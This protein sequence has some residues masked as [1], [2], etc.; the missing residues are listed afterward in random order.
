MST[1]PSAAANISALLVDT[2]PLL[3]LVNRRD[4]HYEWVRTLLAGYTGRLFT[5]E[6]VLS[7]AWFLAQSRLAPPTTL[8]D[9]LDRLPLE[10]VPAW[11]PRVL[12]L[13]RKY[14]DRPMDVAD[15]CLVAL[16]EEKEG[17]VVLTIDR[18]DFSLYRL[19]SQQN[20]PTL[21]PPP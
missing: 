14:A 8:L 16:A 21:M 9:L 5:C 20:V 10:V 15:A 7:E 3:A 13:L 12:A 17:R 6:A 2:G 4:R 1:T 18:E 11:P 19:H